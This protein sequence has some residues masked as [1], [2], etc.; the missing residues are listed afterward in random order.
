MGILPN[1]LPTENRLEDTRRRQFHNSFLLV[2]HL[3]CWKG[4]PLQSPRQG[5]DRS[6]NMSRDYWHPRL[7]SG[8]TS[9]C[10][11]Q[12]R[13]SWSWRKLQWHWLCGCA[14]QQI[15]CEPVYTAENIC[16]WAQDYMN[17]AVKTYVLSKYSAEW[18]EKQHT[19][20]N[21]T[22]IFSLHE[23]QLGTNYIP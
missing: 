1:A 8:Q 4:R 14:H 20:K 13:L 5:K 17:M 3:V 9:Q 10:K 2:M 22:R 12:G 15:P 7:L 11:S 23:K 19:Q 16:T 18:M 6:G 21:F